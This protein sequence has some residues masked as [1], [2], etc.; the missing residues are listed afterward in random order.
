MYVNV[1]Q[2]L[3][4]YIKSNYLTLEGLDWLAGNNVLLTALHGA[5]AG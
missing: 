3:F 4:I 1:K 2:D 5:V